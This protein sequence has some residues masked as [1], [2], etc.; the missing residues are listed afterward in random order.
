MFTQVAHTGDGVVEIVALARHR[1]L[2]PRH[3]LQGPSFDPLVSKRRPCTT[4]CWFAAV[5]LATNHDQSGESQPG[6]GPPFGSLH[7]TVQP[8]GWTQLAGTEPGSTARMAR[9]RYRSTA[10]RDAPTMSTDCTLWTMMPSQA[11]R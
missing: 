9:H 8:A 4:A 7:Y 10:A 1:R 6:T 11:L 3:M 2:S 5:P